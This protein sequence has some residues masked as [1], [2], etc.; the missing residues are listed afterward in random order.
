MQSK[1]AN[2]ILAVGQWDGRNKKFELGNMYGD[3]TFQEHK[4]QP[5]SWGY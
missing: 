4:F 5:S 3:F 1:D 2:C